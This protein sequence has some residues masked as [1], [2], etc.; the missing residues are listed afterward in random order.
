MPHI[1]NSRSPCT[2][3]RCPNKALLTTRIA[4]LAYSCFVTIHAGRGLESSHSTAMA[5]RMPK[6]GSGGNVQTQ[7]LLTILPAVRAEKVARQV[8][9]FAVFHL[10]VWR[11]F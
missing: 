2:E 6:E 8:P 9:T 1:S 11:G 3:R 5:L 10:L 7:T 4:P